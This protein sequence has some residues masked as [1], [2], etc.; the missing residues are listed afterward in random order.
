MGNSN[1]TQTTE[2]QNQQQMI[3]HQ[4]TSSQQQQLNP[5]IISTTKATTHVLANYEIANE[6]SQN[7]IQN[8]SQSLTQTQIKTEQE[9]SMSSSSDSAGEAFFIA[10]LNAITF[11]AAGT[12]YYPIFRRFLEKKFITFTPGYKP[13]DLKNCAKAISEKGGNYGGFRS[14]IASKLFPLCL[15]NA[16]AFNPFVYFAFAPLAIAGSYPLYVNS[17]LKALNLPGYASLK[18]FAELKQLVLQRSSYK[19]L[20]YYLASEILLFVPFLNYF[21]HRFETI[22]L[23]YVFGP[24]FGHEFKTYKEAKQF[25]KVNDGFKHGRFIYNLLPNAFN[26]FATLQILA[27]LSQMGAA[28]ENKI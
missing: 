2:T 3:N 11:S 4:N 6:S 23:A 22:R 15:M 28:L 20:A 10:V 25:V 7:Q 16:T 21:S 18:N 9:S 27:V 5:N 24:Y 13:E 12:L 1:S 14:F 26:L 8:Q 17:N 19:G